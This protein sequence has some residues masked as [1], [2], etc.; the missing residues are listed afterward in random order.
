MKN[1][2][3]DWDNVHFGAD[4][5]KP[6]TNV[7]PDDDLEPRTFASDDGIEG[8]SNKGDDDDDFPL[9]PAP[10]PDPDKPANVDEPPVA[11]N[12]SGIELYLSQFDIEGGIINLEDGTSKHFNDLDA[13]TQAEVLQ[14]L[15]SSQASTVETKYGLDETEIGLLNYLRSNNLTVDEMLDQAVNERVAAMMSVQELALQD[16]AKM[17]SDTLYMK[18]L[19]ESNPEAT[20]DQLAADLAKAKELSNFSKLTDTLRGQYVS[21]QNATLA[22]TN[23]KATQDHQALIESQRQE[24]VQAVL[25][26]N[27]IAGI[28]LDQNIKNTVLDHILETNDEGDSAFMD[29]IFSE[30]EKLFKAAFWYVYGDALVAQRDEYWKK[31]KSAAYKRGKEDALGVSPTPAQGRSF[32]NKP[33]DKKEPHVSAT[34]QRNRDDDGSDWSD[35]H[36]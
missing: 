35:L 1:D 36:T 24:I 13:G 23:A 10:T 5:N 22:E 28:Q 17:D 29:E 4:D 27:E 25:P 20:P 3:Y 11:E 8:S 18:F 32:T 31:E 33:A 26:M 21:Q 34:A 6:A 14:Q 12:M 2:D 19:Q 16:Y 9:V 30:P 7:D 15:H